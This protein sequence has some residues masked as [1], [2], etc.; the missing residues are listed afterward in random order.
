M[1]FAK[2][3]S[4]N[5]GVHVNNTDNYKPSEYNSAEMSISYMGVNQTKRNWQRIETRGG[6]IFENAVQATARDVLREAML[7]LHDN[8]WDIRAHVHDEVICTEPLD[9]R[10]AD[11]MARVMCP[12]IPWAAGLP[13][14]AEGYECSSYRKDL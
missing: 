12:D 7:S 5:R 4:D 10:S 6:R 2:F 3:T 9:G 8:G 14:K 13:L 11:E 1:K